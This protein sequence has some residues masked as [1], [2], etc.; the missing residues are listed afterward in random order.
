MVIK[1]RLIDLEDIS[2]GEL[3]K[4]HDH[5][6]KVYTWCAKN[7]SHVTFYEGTFFFKTE[8]EHMMFMLRWA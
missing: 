2:Q 4:W 7:L 3:R 1:H 8:A 5:E 6:Q